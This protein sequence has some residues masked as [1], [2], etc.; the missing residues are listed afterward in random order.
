MQ[1]ISV[2]GWEDTALGQATQVR[3]EDGIWTCAWR[4]L[5]QK[6]GR[7]TRLLGP[8]TSAFPESFE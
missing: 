3:D 7:P 6:M 5:I 2:Y 4:V 1:R 8:E